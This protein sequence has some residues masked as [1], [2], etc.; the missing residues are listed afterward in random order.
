MKVLVVGGSGTIGRCVVEA[1]GGDHE[2]ITAG[3]NSGDI[4]VDIEDVQSISAMYQQLG[5]FDALISTLGKTHFGPL[6]S[7]TNEQFYLG[8]NNKLMGQVNLVMEGMKTINDKGSFTLTSGILNHE[9]IPLG[10][11]AAMSNGALNAFVKSAANELTR[12]LRINIVSPTVVKEA[13][14]TYGSFFKGYEPVAGS[15]VAQAYRKSLENLSTG[16]IYKVGY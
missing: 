11:S 16:Q 4:Q 1:L 3:R 2:V 12:G 8:L 7:I 6:E 10:V 13:M 15:K 5:S 14:E 9:P